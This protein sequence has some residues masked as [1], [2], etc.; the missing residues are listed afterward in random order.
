MS[1]RRSPNMLAAYLYGILDKSEKA[2]LCPGY[3]FY[4]SMLVISSRGLQYFDSLLTVIWHPFGTQRPPFI[5]CEVLLSSQK[6][7]KKVFGFL[8][9]SVF[10]IELPPF[11]C[12]VVWMSYT[13]SVEIYI[14]HEKSKEFFLL[15]MNSFEG[16]DRDYAHFFVWIIGL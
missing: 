1:Q 14:S 3:K 10:E 5:L 13:L 9:I 2:C 12:N 7:G 16:K 11:S 4:V 8:K 6:D 15:R